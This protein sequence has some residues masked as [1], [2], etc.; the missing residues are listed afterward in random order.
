MLNF[1]ILMLLTILILVKMIVIYNSIEDLI[2]YMYTHLLIIACSLIRV[3]IKK[4]ELSSKGH[5]FKC[6][7]NV[8][9]L[10]L[11]CNGAKKQKGQ[12]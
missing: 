10:I 7:I 4:D 8:Y 5:I 2:I 3:T 6:E 1:N 9:M 11:G 12:N